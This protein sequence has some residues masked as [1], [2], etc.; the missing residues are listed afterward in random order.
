M[1]LGEDP[2]NC[3]LA[4]GNATRVPKNPGGNPPVFK[5]VK[6]GLCA[7]KIS[8]LTGLNFGRQYCTEKRAET[9][10]S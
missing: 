1:Q 2:Q 10:S 7:G 3:A 6:P 8:G 9:E 5:P 4:I